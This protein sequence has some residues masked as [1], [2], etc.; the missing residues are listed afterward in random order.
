VGGLI[1]TAAAGGP[2]SEMP[3]CRELVGDG[4]FAMLFPKGFRRVELPLVRVRAY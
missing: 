2:V 4:A 1:A 3:T